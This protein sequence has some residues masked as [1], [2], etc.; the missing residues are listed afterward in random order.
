MHN[1]VSGPSFAKISDL[2]PQRL[3]NVSPFATVIL[4]SIFNVTKLV[5]LPTVQHCFIFHLLQFEYQQGKLE[6]EVE[7]LS[8]K[9]QKAEITDRGVSGSITGI[10]CYDFMNMAREKSPPKK[11]L[12]KV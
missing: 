7:N 8:W 10:I 2:W 11:N 4:L 9:I 5:N 1:V 6:A 3:F 12:E